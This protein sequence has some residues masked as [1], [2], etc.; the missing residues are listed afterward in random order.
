MLDTGWGP[1]RVA[2]AAE[3]KLGSEVLATLYTAL[4]TRIHHGKEGLG[5]DTVVAAL[6]DAGL[7]AELADAFDSTEYDEAL[8]ASPPRRA[9]TRSATRSARRSS[10]STATAFFGPVIPAVPTGDEAAR[11]FD[12]AA[13][14]P[15]T[16]TSTS[17]SAPAPK[18]PSSTITFARVLV[19]TRRY[20][21]VSERASAQ[22]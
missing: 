9:W 6:A 2:I 7:P 20:G 17:S 4:G 16:P 18:A 1:V 19:P 13:C 14:S 5:Q 21:G 12:G 15:A 11:L 8:R 3:Q 22:T 10:T